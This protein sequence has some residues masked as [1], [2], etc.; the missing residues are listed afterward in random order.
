M[1]KGATG[2]KWSYIGSA[3]TNRRKSMGNWGDVTLI[4]GVI[5]LLITGRGPPCMAQ[6]VYFLETNSKSYLEDRPFAPKKGHTSCSFTIDFQG[7]T[8]SFRGLLIW[9]NIG[10]R[11]WNHQIDFI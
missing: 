4:S 5:S 7:R 9:L 11:V 8:V 3:P 1:Q 10:V 2:A 6:D